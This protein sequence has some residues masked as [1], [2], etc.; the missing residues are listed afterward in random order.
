MAAYLSQTASTQ[1]S[2]T[3]RIYGLSNDPAL[4]DD[5]RWSLNG[6]AW[7]YTGAGNNIA[8]YSGL[9]C[10]TNYSV[11]AEAKWKGTW[12]SAG[13]MTAS[14][15]ACSIPAPGSP[16]ISVSSVGRT[17]ASIYV[18]FGSNTNYVTVTI[19]GSGQSNTAYSSGTL[20]FS[21]L[22]SATTYTVTCTAYGSG[23]STSGSNISLSTYPYSPGGDASAGIQSVIINF[24]RQGD[25]NLV[26]AYVAPYMQSSTASSGTFTFSGL[27]AGQSYYPSIR[28]RG[29][30]G[31]YSDWIPLGTIIPLAPAVPPSAPTVSIVPSYTKV[32]VT[33]T[34]GV[35]TTYVNV[36]ICPDGSTTQIGPTQVINSSGG[37]VSFTGLTANTNYDVLYR[38]YNATLSGTQE[39]RDTKTL[40]FNAFSWGTTISSGAPVVLTASKWLELQ[41]GINIKRVEKGL[42][43]YSFTGASYVSSG[44]PI[45]AWLANQFITSMSTIATGLPASVSSGDAISASWL[46]QLTNSYNNI[47]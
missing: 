15:S 9:T 20:N 5:F 22:S 44:L 18:S 17:T 4:Y 28:A 16:S 23:G 3:V 32:D 34:F 30:N 12:Y 37:T 29:N 1:T 13:S 45:Y 14:T 27:T 42:S 41:N 24:S 2:I 8:Y 47:T 36:I 11:V 10:G 43:N 31:V 19:T 33:V 26:E 39:K 35:N 38:P 40:A 21:G 46:N 6:G 25:S 7:G